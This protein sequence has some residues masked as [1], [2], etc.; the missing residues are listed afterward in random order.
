[1]VLQS[2]ECGQQQAE[3]CAEG[4]GKD[5]VAGAHDVSSPLGTDPQKKRCVLYVPT[6]KRR[7]CYLTRW[8]GDPDNVAAPVVALPPRLCGRKGFASP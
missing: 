7:G 1:M 8:S 3:G 6:G 2:D 4:A 5:D